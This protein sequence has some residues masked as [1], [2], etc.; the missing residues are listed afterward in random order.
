MENQL[1]EK[2]S[3]LQNREADLQSIGSKVNQLTAQLA[4]LADAK[5]QEIGLLREGLAQ[6][7]E[8]LQV[9]DDAIKNLEE[10][11]AA[12]VS[13]L[14]NQ[15]DEK[16][17]LLQ[18]READLQSIGSK[19]DQLTAQLAELADMKIGKAGCCARS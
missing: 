1:S 18:N 7:S 5:D 13:A 15:L 9:K 10:Q 8:F 19:V 6:R 11:L 17:S 4:E 12:Q 3:L 14:E 2:Q 16:Q